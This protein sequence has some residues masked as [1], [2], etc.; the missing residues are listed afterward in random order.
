[1]KRLLLVLI[2]LPLALSLQAQESTL[3]VQ[4]IMQDP[5]WIGHSPSEL[6]WSEDGA[7]LYFMWNPEQH[8]GDSLYK[9]AASGSKPQKVSPEERRGLP[10]FSGVYNRDY[11]AKLYTDNG[12]L[13]LIS[14]DKAG[15]I[16]KTRQLTATTGREGNPAFSQDESKV[17]YTRDDDLYAL[18]LNTGLTEQLTDFRNSGSRGSGSDG[19]EDATWLREDQLAYI[20]ILHERNEKEEAE[21]K[22][23]EQNAPE[24]PLAIYSGGKAIGNAQLSPDERYVTYYISTQSSN[25]STEVPNYV[26]ES[27]YTE[28]LSARAKV[29]TNTS[30]RT[31]GIYDR[32]AEKTYQID[33]EDIP[34]IRETPEY[35]VEQ[36]DSAVMDEDRR[37]LSYGPYWSH[38]GSKAFVVLRSTDNKD[39]WFMLL[40]PGTGGLS[41]IDRQHDPAW[42]NGPGIG[43]N[44]QPG[45]CGWMPDNQSIW[46]Q[47]EASGYSH[48]YVAD[49]A[50]GKSKAF[51]S[52]NWEVYDVALSPDKRSFY[53]TTNEVHPGE[54]QYY[55]MDLKGKN[56]TRLTKREGSH[57]VS[58]S[59]KGKTIASL[60]SSANQPW[61][62]Y[63]GS[64][65]GELKRVT[66]SQTE[67]WKSYP[68]RVPELVTFDAQDGAQ[69]YARLYQPENPHPNKPAVVFVHGA[70]YLQ[71][72]HKWWSGYFRE[73]MFHNLLADLGYTVLDIDYRGS[74]GYGRDWR[75]G[76]Y[77]HMGGKD[78]SDQ[79]DGAKFLVDTYGINA[80]AIGIYGGSYGGFITLM[81]MFTE[82]GTFKAGAALRSVTDWAHYNHPYTS[83]ILNIP[84]SDTLAYRRSSP[85]YHAEGLQDPLLICHGMIDTNVQFQ[86]VVRLAQRLIELG[87][88]DWEMAVY[89]LE[90]HGFVEPSSWTDEYSRILKLMEENLK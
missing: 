18:H 72:A 49:V 14:L 33:T 63:L 24:R 86:D 40:D 75:T 28:M 73:Y 7:W 45:N 47:S 36:G 42:I 53:L 61:E 23:E 50:N 83:N 4:K 11:S 58:L 89:P 22:W 65:G 15:R 78:L 37:F 64:T 32:Q 88:E 8:P 59:P 70:G 26:T 27:G 80:D 81:A 66:Y 90:G 31:I 55:R 44:Y 46:F 34:G 85:I 67:D 2:C 19:D 77:R 69:V 74:Q 17:L 79:V 52:G 51:T 9:V 5:A 43:Y 1:M 39:R 82:P 54:R 87:K 71:N 35:R 84:V 57:Q 30:H 13:F 10:S 21:D 3:S 60:Y 62:I 25:K 38:D 41:L 68:W 48:L 29:G 6:H 76:I 16:T 20:Q 56:K 12:D